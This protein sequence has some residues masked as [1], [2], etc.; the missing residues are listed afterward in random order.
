MKLVPSVVLALVI[1]GVVTFAYYW[2]FLNVDIT[3]LELWK[4]LPYVHFRVHVR[5]TPINVTFDI[6]VHDGDRVIHY[7]YETK[8]F[9]QPR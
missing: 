8:I 5:K 4:G 6:T 9:T 7:V 3:N 1:I 2:I